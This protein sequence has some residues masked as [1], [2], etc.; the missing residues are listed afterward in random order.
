MDVSWIY[1]CDFV[2]FGASCHIQLEDHASKNHKYQ[3]AISQ[4]GFARYP[5]NV[6]HKIKIQTHLDIHRCLL[7]WL[8]DTVILKP[9]FSSYLDIEPIQLMQMMSIQSW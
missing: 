9:Y 6:L 1:S 2:T 8:I 5:K 7:I 3:P 4:E